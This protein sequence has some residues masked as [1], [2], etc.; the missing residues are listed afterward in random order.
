MNQNERDEKVL[1][2][3]PTKEVRL[4]LPEQNKA[5]SPSSTSSNLTLTVIWS[6]GAS[7]S[8]TMEVVEVVKEYPTINFLDSGRS[9]ETL[10]FSMG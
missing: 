3:A 1:T 8:W 6:L 9:T 7:A 10:E 2:K 4:K 5:L